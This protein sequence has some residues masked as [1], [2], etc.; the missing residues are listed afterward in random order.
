MSPRMPWPHAGGVGGRIGRGRPSLVSLPD[1][2]HLADLAYLTQRTRAAPASGPRVCSWCNPPFD[3]RWS[4]PKVPGRFTHLRSPGILPVMTGLKQ[5][6]DATP[7]WCGSD[8]CDP[9]SVRGTRRRDLPAGSLVASRIRL[10]ELA[11]QASSRQGYDRPA[12]PLVSKAEVRRGRR[13]PRAQG[14]RTGCQ[15]RPDNAPIRG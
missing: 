8:R 12:G 2:A 5:W 11:D 1:V 14:R 7:R 13:Q 9:G 6:A 10:G 15:R 3:T 4:S